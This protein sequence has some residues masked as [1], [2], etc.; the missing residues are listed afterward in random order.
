MAGIGLRIGALGPLEVHLGGEPVPIGS[1]K[2]R[3][4]LGI[5][6]AHGGRVVSTDRLI[7]ELWTADDSADHQ[8]ALW[9]HISNLR[10]VLG[11]DTPVLVTRTPG[12]L[13]DVTR[14]SSD[15]AEFERLLAEGRALADTDPAAA[16]LVLGEALG[17][18]R[19]RPYEDFTYDS[20]AE[21]EISRL[22]ELRM[23]AVELRIDCDLR[24]GL[25]TELVG[26]LEGLV[27]EHPLRERLTG[28]LMLALYRSGRQADALRACQRLRT[29]LVDE[30]GVDLST[31][32]QQL[33]DRIVSG[34]P[35]LIA[36]TSSEARRGPAV[37]ATRCVKRSPPG[38]RARC[39]GSTSRRL[40]EKSC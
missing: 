10:K 11:S 19:G 39:I 12:Y 31:A 30:L 35:A 23:D 14:V 7:D 26:E 6:F 2:Q 27:R 9:V 3:A 13:L 20:W 16:A 22:N 21:P 24:R 34:D 40:V 37:R 29:R 28:S 17:L 1:G 5:L 8:N 36:A 32:I 33:E 38:P 15:I 25:T 4:V 18:W